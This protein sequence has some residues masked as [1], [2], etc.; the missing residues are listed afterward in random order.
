MGTKDSEVPELQIWYALSKQRKCQLPVTTKYELPFL[1][2]PTFDIGKCLLEMNC[3]ITY[4]GFWMSTCCQS[5]QTVFLM[6][7]VTELCSEESVKLQEHFQICIFLAFDQFINII[8]SECNAQLF[9]KQMLLIIT[10][11]LQFLQERHQQ[12]NHISQCILINCKFKQKN[13]NTQYSSKM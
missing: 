1:F 3:W 7:N 10:M 9:N 2:P 11:Q 8:S 13:K 5:N 4:Y 12:S 6:L